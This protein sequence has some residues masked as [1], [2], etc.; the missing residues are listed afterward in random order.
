[1][2][3]PP[4]NRED[5]PAELR[6][7]VRA[8]PFCALVTMTGQGMVASH[9]PVVLHESANGFGVLRG[10]LARA[11]SHWRHFDPAAEALVIFTGPHHFI[12]ASWYP[13]KQVHGRVVPTWNYVAVH[14]YGHLRIVEDSDWLLD[15]LRSLVDENESIA[16]RPW[17]ISDG[18][19]EFIA[20]QMRAIVGF[21]IEVS[22]VEGKW[23]VSQNRDDDDAAGVV[24]ALRTLDTAASHEMSRLIEQRRPRKSAPSTAPTAPGENPPEAHGKQ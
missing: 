11:N 2:Y 23:K 9:V 20:G 22:R 15:H 5:D 10:H 14:A 19:P 7:F 21:E 18:P 13:S 8:H 16:E 3:I 12:S 6:R 4:V 17:S 1:V 24:A